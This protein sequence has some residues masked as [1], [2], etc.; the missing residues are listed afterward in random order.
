MKVKPVF[1]LSLI[2]WC[3]VLVSQNSELQT[4][5]GAYPYIGECEK[6][7][8]IGEIKTCLNQQLSADLLFKLK[9]LGY[10][11]LDTGK[12]QLSFVVYSF[13]KVEFDK[14]VCLPRRAENKKTK[15]TREKLKLAFLEVLK[16]QNWI[17]PEKDTSGF[18]IGI[19]H[20]LYYYPK[21]LN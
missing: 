2:V 12:Y 6:L 17:Y 19:G 5:E 21:A 11:D 3:S 13:G 20:N 15:E 16:E 7:N 1:A 9:S 14:I 4:N 8:T 10:I 18:D